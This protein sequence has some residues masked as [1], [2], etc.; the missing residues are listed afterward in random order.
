MRSLHRLITILS[1]V[2][3]LG[4]CGGGGSGDA[5]PPA[6]G[7]STPPPSISGT[8]ATGAS[9][10]GTVVAIGTNGAQATTS[11]G[12]GG[13]YTLTVDG[14]TFPLLVKAYNDVGTVL[15]SWADASG[16]IANLTPLTTLALL[17]SELPDNLTELFATGWTANV[18]AQLT[19]SAMQAAQAKVNANLSSPLTA[20]GINPRNYDFLTTPFI[21]D[22]SGIDGVLDTLHFSFNFL[23]NALAN[24]VTLIPAGATTPVVLNINIDTSAIVI[25]GAGGG[26]GSGS[27]NGLTFSQ[28]IGGLTQLANSTANF[29]PAPGSGSLPAEIILRIG[30]W[31]SVESVRLELLYTSNTKA[32]D[33]TITSATAETLDVTINALTPYTV[34][35]LDIIPFGCLL[36]G[37]TLD[38]SRKR[39]SDMGITFDR[40]SGL[41]SFNATPMSGAVNAGAGRFTVSGSMNFTPF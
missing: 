9:L 21:T 8:A 38:T 32:H 34:T 37:T 6:G 3:V 35:H 22:G 13:K 5:P 33:T 25:G 18:A 7:S 23:G 20:K 26:S 36:S 40:A 12:T 11:I 1:F 29:V 14:L 27:G 17:L 19:P 15:Y 41:V 16:D 4:A 10:A 28:A 31:G 30:T 24:I 39:C 2:T